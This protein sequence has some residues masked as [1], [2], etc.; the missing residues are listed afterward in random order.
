MS[1]LTTPAWMIVGLS[2]LSILLLGAFL[3]VSVLRSHDEALA[4]A[5]QRG[6]SQALALERHVART[7]DSIDGAIQ[8][9]VEAMARTDATA[10][11]FHARLH[12]MASDHPQIGRIAIVDAEGRLVQSSFDPPAQPV[13]YSDRE[14]F[15]IHRDHAEVGLFISRPTPGRAVST[16]TIPISRRITDADGKFAGVVVVALDP[17]YFKGFLEAVDLGPNSVLTILRDDGTIIARAPHG[18][19][20]IGKSA[21]SWPIFFKAYP[22]SSAASYRGKLLDDGMKRVVSYRQ[23]ENF[24]LIAAVGIATADAL[25]GWYQFLRETAVLWIAAALLVA[26]FAAV[27]LVAFRRRALVEGTFRDL[28]E[29]A[30]DGMVIIDP[31]DRIHLVN[32]QAEKL[33]GYAREE[34]L[35]QPFQMLIAERF[36]ERHSTYVAAYRRNPRTRQMGSGLDLRARRKDGSEFPVEVSLS[37]LQT[38]GSVLISSAIRDVTVRARIEAELRETNQRLGAL[39]HATPLALIELD[40][41]ALVQSWNPAAQK[42]FGWRADEVMGKPLPAVLEKHR[43][44]MLASLEPQTGGSQIREIEIQAARKDSSII[45]IAVWSAPLFDPHGFGSGWIGIIADITQ[46]KQADDQLRQSQRL[47]AI[48][49]LTGGVAHEFNNLLQVIVGNLEALAD[50][51]RGPRDSEALELIM[52]AA[53]RGADLTQQLLAVS[54]KQPLQPKLFNPC[55]EIR[56]F[57]KLLHATIGANYKIVVDAASDVSRVSADQTQLS[58]AILNLVLNARDAMPE[59]GDITVR[60]RN[61]DLDRTDAKRLDVVPGRYVSIEIIDDGVGMEPAVADRAIEPFFTTKDVGKGTGLG[62]SMAHGFVRQSG[63]GLDIITERGKG[64]TV[65]LLLPAAAGR[66]D[67]MHE[68]PRLRLVPNRNATILVVE[69]EAYVLATTAALLRSL[70][71]RV[72]E[73][74]DGP[75]A[76]VALKVARRVDA[77]FTDIVMPKGMSGYDLARQA[78]AFQPDLKVIYTSGYADSVLAEQGGADRDD[79]LLPKPYTKSELAAA[80]EHVLGNGNKTRQ[81]V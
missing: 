31:Q 61:A 3:A 76:L 8:L 81:Q 47:Q 33:F 29:S 4:D 74:A 53:R 16:W 14:F 25:A 43:N 57:E 63:G 34:L 69:D 72:I 79:M 44:E 56:R 22:R 62:L 65:R 78:R 51:T 49:Q 13:N 37:P 54:R 80:I 28:L 42:M 71:Y 58:N 1:R 11:D 77:L 45:D 73:A 66:A 15:A 46:K 50:S 23:I 21:S 30:P 70:G 75:A 7:I 38:N 60:L 24:P 64:T 67:R 68:A 52:R 39:I 19:E 12:R 32:A 10:P 35:G 5:E 27:A 6:R 26:I 9:I 41:N 20:W 40:R 18:D 59:G 36:W 2:L 55:D 17:E 48:G